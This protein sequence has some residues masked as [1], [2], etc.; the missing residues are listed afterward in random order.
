MI[1]TSQCGAVQPKMGCDR[2]APGAIYCPSEVMNERQLTQRALVSMWLL[3]GSGCTLGVLDELSGGDPQTSDRDGGMDAGSA[4]GGLDGGEGGTSPVDGGGDGGAA[5]AG[6]DSGPGEDACVTAPTDHKRVFITSTLFPG[7]LGSILASDL[8]C[9]NIANALCL[10]GEWRAW[11]SADN[12]SAAMRFT[13]ATVPYRLLDGTQV[14]DDWTDLTDGSLDAAINLDEHGE[15][16]PDNQQQAWTGTTQ[17][18]NTFPSKHCQNWTS[19]GADYAKFGRPMNNDFT[20]TAD[21][22]IVCAASARLYCFEQ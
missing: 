19:S 9:Q 7:P 5:D 20:W 6:A 17:A 12:N 10:G 21:H 13:H 8:R 18:G 22:D 1:L 14:A 2:S 4:D 3:W 16:M 15:P 11:L